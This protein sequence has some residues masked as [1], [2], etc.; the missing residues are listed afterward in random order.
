MAK[1]IEKKLKELGFDGL[2]VKETDLKEDFVLLKTQN[3]DIKSICLL[4]NAF[5]NV[6]VEVYISKIKN[7]KII[8]LRYRW[9]YLRGSNSY[10][11]WHQL[12]ENSNEWIEH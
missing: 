6:K 4:N 11:V 9:E 5:K 1:E 3:I 2:F 7:I 12:L 10:T 8:Q